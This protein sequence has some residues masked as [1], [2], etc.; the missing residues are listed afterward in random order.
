LSNNALLAQAQELLRQNGTTAV[1]ESMI[2]NA[3]GG[4]KFGAVLAQQG[5]KGQ[6]EKVLNRFR[7]TDFKY[8]DSMLEGYD[9]QGE[10]QS[11]ILSVS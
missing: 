1:I 11:H 2:S 9:F 10:G 7:D 6:L 5:N 3:F 4:G 8:I